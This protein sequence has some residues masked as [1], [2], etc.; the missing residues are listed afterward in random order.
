[1]GI[2]GWLKR[3]ERASAQP[4]DERVTATLNRIV[5][6]DPQLA[7][8]QK[9][10]ARMAPAVGTCIDHVG[11]LVASL[12]G[13]RDANA[14]SWSSDACIHAF[15]A[16]PDDVALVFSRSHDMR[17]FFADNPD[18]THAYAV[19]SMAMIERRVLGVAQAGEHA[20]PDVVQTT[21]SFSDHRVRI[22]ARTD[23]ELRDDIV[24]RVVD[25]LVLDGLQGVADD[26]SRREVLEE[27]RALLRTRLQLLERQ[28]AGMS[29]VLG[30][31]PAVD[32]GELARLQARI[33]ENSRNLENLGL[34]MDALERKFDHVHDVLAAPA[35]RIHV[36]VKRLRLDKMNVVMTDASS[37]PG[38]EIEFPLARIPGPLQETRAF[39]IV[40]FA[41]TDLLP[42]GNMF[43]EAARLL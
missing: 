10:R 18:M 24:R 40:R 21:V 7:L 8:V 29:A 2:F 11:R 12:P 13:S 39:S 4:A 1:V 33:E 17:A 5:H 34:P 42:T 23:A 38:D 27:E 14:A 19:L 3:N 28:G 20:R 9:Y 16:I 25:Q 43:D 31:E 35:S 22:C 30:G 36:D 26:A 37:Q 6:L 32:V 41:R 15:F